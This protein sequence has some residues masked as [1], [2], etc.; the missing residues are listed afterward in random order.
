MKQKLIIITGPTASGKTDAA[1]NIAKKRG[2]F[3]ILS[4][5]S[6]QVYRNMDIGTAKVPHQ[7]R[8]T[9]P[10]HLID[11]ID[12]NE[13]YSLGKYMED[14]RKILSKSAEDSKCILVVGGTGLY[15][16]GLTHGIFNGPAADWEFRK[17]LE[18][19][20]EEKGSI[21]LH[22]KLNE[23]DAVSAARLHPEDH[24]RVIRAL[25]VY[26]KSGISISEL[27]KKYLNKESEFDY[28]IF[29]INRPKPDLHKLI[30]KRVD[31][32]FEKGFIDEVVQL[33]DDP[34]GLSRQASQALGYKELLRYLNNEIDLQATKDL[35]KQNTRQF[36][37][38]QLTWFRSF[39]DSCWI[40]CPSDNSN[41]M[42][43][44]TILDE[45]EKFYEDEVPDNNYQYAAS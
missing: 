1:L 36:A 28:K 40:D 22:N 45:I 2:S 42:V 21:Y 41:E 43:S 8:E 23:V 37:K 31:D 9:I 20:V 7:V 10:H 18:A 15:I 27:Q 26:E 38:R 11:I 4:A 35:I 3:E 5:D 13:S 14:A 24:Q 30:E 32:M 34:R 19:V 39:K 17:Q 33:R 44:R 6:M 16:R 25:E 29:I 12:A